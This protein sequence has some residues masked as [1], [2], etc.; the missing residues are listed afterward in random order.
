MIPGTPGQIINDLMM[1][2]ANPIQLQLPY[3]GWRLDWMY[4][5]DIPRPDRWTVATF[6][7]MGRWWDLMTKP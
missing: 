3:S 5:K 7:K 4:D 1:K 2:K 6:R